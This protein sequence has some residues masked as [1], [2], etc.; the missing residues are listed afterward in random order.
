MANNKRTSEVTDEQEKVHYILTLLNKLFNTNI[1]LVFND[2]AECQIT[3]LLLMVDP[4]VFTEKI[5]GMSGSTSAMSWL[6]SLL[7]KFPSVCSQA[8]SKG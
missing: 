5:G 2:T 1:T 3:S 7:G 4:V 6:V 8:T